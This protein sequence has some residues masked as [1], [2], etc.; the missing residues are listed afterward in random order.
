MACFQSMHFTA[1]II[2]TSDSIN[3]HGHL[4]YS[5]HRIKIEHRGHDFSSQRKG[6]CKPLMMVLGL[7]DIN[8]L[9]CSTPVMARQRQRKTGSANRCCGNGNDVE[10]IN[11]SIVQ[12]RLISDCF[13]FWLIIGQKPKCATLLLI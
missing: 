3:I 11:R 2:I 1:L 7:H 4:V 12:P 13:F 10:C 6:T 5:A 9:H 8:G